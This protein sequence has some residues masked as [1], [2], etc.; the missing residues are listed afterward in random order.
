MRLRL[1][2]KDTTRLVLEGEDRTL[3]LGER[4]LVRLHLGM[5]QGCTRFS[6]QVRLMQGALD[7]WRR[8]AEGGDSTDTLRPPTP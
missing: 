7:G 3:A 1:T 8:Y 2:C 5:C 4:V 6:R